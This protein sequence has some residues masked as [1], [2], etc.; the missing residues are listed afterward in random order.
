MAG[1]LMAVDPNARKMACFIT[2]CG[3]P[4]IISYN[5]RLPIVVY[6]PESVEVLYRRWRAEANVKAM[7]KG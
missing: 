6:A 1:T 3:A 7:A 2:R 5:S 4:Y